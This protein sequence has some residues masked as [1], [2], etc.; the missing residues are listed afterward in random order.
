MKKQHRC[1]FGGSEGQRLWLPQVL[2]SN[3]TASL[4][5]MPCAVGVPRLSS[6]GRSGRLD[7][8]RAFQGCSEGCAAEGGWQMVHTLSYG[9]VTR[10][11]VLNRCRTKYLPFSIFLVV[12]LII[13]Q[14]LKCHSSGF[15]QPTAK[16]FALSTSVTFE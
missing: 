8:H 11:Q 6:V 4:G 12:Y 1:G 13:K 14:T 9:K 16:L 10:S 2:R 15:L 5:A 7:L 3:R